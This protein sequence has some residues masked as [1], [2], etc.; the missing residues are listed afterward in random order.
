MPR[1]AGSSMAR[2]PASASRIW[3][4]RLVIGAVIGAIVGAAVGAAAFSVLGTDSTATSLVRLT[5]PPELMAIATGADRNT[6]DTD[7]YITQY[8]TGEVAY[9]SGDGF[10]RAV[11]ASLGQSGPAR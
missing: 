2:V 6:P 5:P 3:V 11:G 7:V 4:T 9:L 1:A 10:T 8:M